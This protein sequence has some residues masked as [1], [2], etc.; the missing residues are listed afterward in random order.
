MKNRERKPRVVR[1][2]NR[3]FL[4]LW[5]LGVCGYSAF[6]QGNAQTPKSYL[7]KGTVHLP[8]QIDD[9]VRPTLQEVQLWVK[10]TPQA[11]WTIKEKVPGTQTFFTYRAARD[12]EYWFNVV[13][14]DRAGRAIP[15]DVS[16]E[17]PGLIVVID[18]TPPRAEPKVLAVT[19]EGQQIRCEITD[20]NPDPSKTRLY[21]Q[22]RDQ[23]WARSTRSA[24]S[25]TPF[26]FRPRPPSA[27]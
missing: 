4:T 20:L 9:R 10:E 3:L 1:W 5:G 11:P 16:K 15:A 25:P 23:I 26:A 21:Y 7:N 12:G 24:A 8:I 6:A 2:A 27:A 13:T 18:S 17:P 22:T 14:V 19:P